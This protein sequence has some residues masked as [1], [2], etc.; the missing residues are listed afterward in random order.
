MEKTATVIVNIGKD[1]I[2][3]KTVTVIVK[4]IVGPYGGTFEEG[5]VL[6]DALNRTFENACHIILDFEGMR[7]VS[8]SFINGGIGSWLSTSNRLPFSIINADDY[9]LNIIYHL[10]KAL[11]RRDEIE[12]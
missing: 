3:E 10:I 2:M 8:S 4:D 1:S 5:M 7:I 6:A 9:I 11:V 12:I